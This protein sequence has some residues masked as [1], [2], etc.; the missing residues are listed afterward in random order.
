[1]GIP[2]GFVWQCLVDAVVEVLVV[3]ENDMATDIV[4]LDIVSFWKSL[5]KHRVT[6]EAFWGDIGG[7]KST[8]GLVGVDN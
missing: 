3:G 7:G 5:K 6:Y 8:R 4:K 2:V 1:V